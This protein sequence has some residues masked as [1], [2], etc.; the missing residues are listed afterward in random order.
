M[1]VALTDNNERVV[2]IVRSWFRWLSTAYIRAVTAAVT[3]IV[4]AVSIAILGWVTPL[5]IVILAAVIFAVGPF[6]EVYGWARFVAQWRRNGLPG[7]PHGPS[8]RRF[9]VTG[10]TQLALI[11]GVALGCW[12]FLIVTWNTVSLPLI[13]LL[14]LVFG[15]VSVAR[16]IRAEITVHVRSVANTDPRAAGQDAAA[17]WHDTTG[18]T[19][20]YGT[21]L[22]RQAG[23]S[24]GGAS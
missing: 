8:R 15:E 17:V 4:L 11:V 12:G 3:A 24:A 16:R 7:L 2:D 1:F 9:I 18:R 10:I 23:E 6:G 21:A 20:F 14:P 5:Y 22:A 13:P 19:G